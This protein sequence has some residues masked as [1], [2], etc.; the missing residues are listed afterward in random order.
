MAMVLMQGNVHQCFLKISTITPS[1]MHS[2]RRHN[3]LHGT[4]LD[5]G[6]G[7]AMDEVSSG[8]EGVSVHLYSLGGVE[9]G[10]HVDKKK[11]LVLLVFNQEILIQDA[12]L[13]GITMFYEKKKGNELHMI[14]INGPLNSYN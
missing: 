1:Q 9:D 14:K 2:G 4:S 11:A 6:L 13:E 7:K 10:K 12:S 3:K 8:P 5:L